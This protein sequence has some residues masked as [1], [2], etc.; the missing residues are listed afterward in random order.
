[1]K[2]LSSGKNQFRVVAMSDIK[3]PFVTEKFKK[4]VK[5][6]KSHYSPYLPLTSE[7]YLL[8]PDDVIMLRNYTRDIWFDQKKQLPYAHSFGGYRVGNT[9]GFP[10]IAEMHG[11]NFLN[12]CSM[13]FAIEKYNVSDPEQLSPTAAALGLMRKEHLLAQFYSYASS[14]FTKVGPYNT[15]FFRECHTNGRC[16]KPRFSSIFVNVQ[17]NGINDE[18]PKNEKLGRLFGDWFRTTFPIPSRFE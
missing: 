13:R 1:M 8:V 9:R 12:R 5:L 6:A 14:A 2:N 10:N 3:V 4:N 7:Y 16:I 17:G 11:V 15:V 18:Y